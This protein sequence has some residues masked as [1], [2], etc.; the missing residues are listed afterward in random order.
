[1]VT[2][3]LDLKNDTDTMIAVKIIF[4]AAMSVFIGSYIG[5]S[6]RDVVGSNSGE[7]EYRL[8]YKS[9][10]SNALV[11][12][13]YESTV[14]SPLEKKKKD[15]EEKPILVDIGRITVP[16]FRPKNVTYL[17]VDMGVEIVGEDNAEKLEDALLASRLRADILASFVKLGDFGVFNEDDINEEYV[18]SKVYDVIHKKYDLVNKIVFMNFVLQD[19]IKY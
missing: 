11:G 15:E 13:K 16:V 12:E 4:M 10:V 18:N 19:A 7:S 5:Y 9:E 2:K 17:V 14:I 8:E 1:M 6:L 3:L